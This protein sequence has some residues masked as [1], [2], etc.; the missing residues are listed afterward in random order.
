MIRF[1]LLDPERV[2][3]HE[4]GHAVVAH[5]HRYQVTK[6]TVQPNYFPDDSD[7]LYTGQVIYDPPWPDDDEATGAT[8]YTRARTMAEVS[9]GGRA[10]EIE[11]FGELQP[12]D[13]EGHAHDLAGVHHLLRV[14][15]TP[16]TE[17]D[18]RAYVERAEKKARD[19]LRRNWPAMTRIAAELQDHR[20][21]DHEVLQELLKGI[22]RRARWESD[23]R[24]TKKLDPVWG[25]YYEPAE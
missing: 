14:V 22:P 7:D 19:I 10:A 20:T 17:A 2:P 16:K 24:W 23:K 11:K 4:A 8:W 12:A 13:E 6:A 5:Y 9:L 1:E 3:I 25:E 15:Y 21:L 18:T